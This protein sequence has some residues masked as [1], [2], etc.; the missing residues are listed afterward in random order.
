M[1][2]KD[3]KKVSRNG[4]ILTFRFQIKEDIKAARTEVTRRTRQYVEE[5]KTS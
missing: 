3:I 2:G 4:T 5:L 1:D